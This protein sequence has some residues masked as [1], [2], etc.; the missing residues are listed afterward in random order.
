[1]GRFECNAEQG[2][3]VQQ[4]PRALWGHEASELGLSAQESKGPQN[5][6]CTEHEWVMD[7]RVPA[8]MRR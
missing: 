2:P 3:G 6:V 5:G 8:I 4:Y 7:F 1:M